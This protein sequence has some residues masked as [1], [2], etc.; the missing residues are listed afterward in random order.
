MQ[1]D[2]WILICSLCYT[3]EN[4]SEWFLGFEVRVGLIVVFRFYEQIIY[5]SLQL[6]LIDIL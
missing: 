3:M 2:F 4:L 6:A 1:Y 5:S